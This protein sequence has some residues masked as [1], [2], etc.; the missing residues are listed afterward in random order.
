ME[1]KCS[2]DFKHCDFWRKITS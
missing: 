1:K 2:F